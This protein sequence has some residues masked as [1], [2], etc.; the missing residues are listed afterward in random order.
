MDD[1]AEFLRPLFQS[2]VVRFH[3]PPRASA[4]P[5]DTSRALLRARHERVCLDLAGPPPP[6][7]ERV[8]IRAAG[9]VRSICWSLVDRSEPAEELARRVRLDVRP[10]RPEDH[11]AADL[12]FRYLPAILRRAHAI[13][14][15]DPLVEIVTEVLREWPLSGVL[16]GLDDGPTQTP[17]FGDQSGIALLYAERFAS[18]PRSA[19]RPSG[20]AGDWLERL[21]GEA[22]VTVT[23]SDDYGFGRSSP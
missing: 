1:L 21:S 17:D 7:S 12:T 11:L 10:E 19:W 13:D 9:F 22:A 4:E 8:A 2:G 14:S 20:L 18:R 23:T 5:L 3:E 15:A 16:A 6:F